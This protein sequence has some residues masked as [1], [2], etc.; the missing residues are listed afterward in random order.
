MKK[1]CL[2]FIVYYLL[3]IVYCF[4]QTIKIS[5]KVTDAL[6]NESIPFA[7]ITFQGTNIGTTSDINGNYLIETS[8]PS[9]TLIASFIGYQRVLMRII[10]TKSQVI[11]F[12]LKINKIDLPEV[13]IKPGKNPALELL[14]KI[15]ENK[16]KNNKTHL[17]AYQYEVYTKGEFDI[18]NISEKFKKKKIIKPFAFVFEQM[19]TEATNKKA[20]LPVFITETLSDFYYR[21]NP[22]AQ[23][24]YI[25]ASK[26]SGVENPT[27]IQFLGDMY[28]NTNVYDN[29]INVFG[30]SFVSPLANIGQ[31]YY[32]YYLVDSAFIGDKWCYKITYQPRRKQELTFIGDFW[33]NDTTFAI[34]KI[35]ARIAND[36]NINFIDDMAVVQEFE[37][38]NN[39]QW[40]ISKDMLVIDFVAKEEGMSV[41][42]RKTTSYKKFVLN[43]PKTTDFF[44]KGDNITVDDNALNKDENFWN[45]ARHDSLSQREK[46]IYAMVDTIQS[47]PA[48]QTWVDIVTLFFSG[49]KEFGKIELGPYYTL[50]SFNAI[51]GNRIRLG[52]RTSNNFS[53]NVI[54]DGYVAYGT[55]DE[56]FKYKGGIQYYFS[57]KPRQSI[58]LS[59]KNDQ[60]QLG[61]SENAFQEDNILGSILRRVQSNKRTD[62]EE[63]KFYY[64]R[65]WFPGLSNR[66][67]FTHRFYLPVY[68]LDYSYYTDAAKTNVKNSLLTSELSL[69]TRF[70]YREKFLAGKVDRISL[71]TK[72]PVLQINYVMG[73]KG[74]LK[75]DFAYHK[76]T[77]KVND[78]FS[79]AP[80]GW[81]YY[82]AE[83]GKTWGTIPYPLLE[84]HQGN[85][86][87]TFDDMAFNMM[88]YYEFVSDMH[89][90]FSMTHHFDGFFM[91]KIPLMRKLKWRE[92][93]TLKGVIGNFSEKNRQILADPNAFSPLRKP[94]FETGVGI[95][96]I[97]KII[98]IDALWRLSY[99]DKDYTLSQKSTIAKFGIRGSLMLSF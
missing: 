91:N 37:M 32:R 16:D 55:K 44:L 58:G 31:V 61:K 49:Y 98:R 70:A 9:D 67:S 33:V 85:E 28:Q 81:T 64:E 18:S 54:L 42:G 80:F 69:Y 20:F 59:Y 40:M 34:K 48:F 22:K 21:S 78:N 50:Y 39:K 72:Y 2:L 88:N 86:T 82:F 23:K 8:T 77:L 19:D 75:S 66:L 5:G 57:K 51:E 46:K 24:E 29:F 11:N 79:L 60:E 15:I 17:D 94:Y 99:I 53:T 89:A 13:V 41:I 76:I 26:V 38:V 63:E 87:Y 95:E 92:L 10:K 3:F 4:A 71:G 36:A 25:K 96:N 62:I 7:N 1:F 6:T 97:F 30:K 12:S 45:E 84:V 27:I 93:Y 74:T 65:E 14:E 52:G 56:K 43:E 83:A 90:S 68:P 35:N 47:L 73:L